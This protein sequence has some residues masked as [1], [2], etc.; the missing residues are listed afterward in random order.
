LRYEQL[1]VCHIICIVPA[2]ETNAAMDEKHGKDND[3]EASDDDA[4]GTDAAAAD[5]GTRASWGLRTFTVLQPDSS[6]PHRPRHAC[7]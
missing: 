6:Q 2:A 5:D 4:S 7:D 3:K 1:G